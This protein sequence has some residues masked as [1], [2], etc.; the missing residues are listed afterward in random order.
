MSK[1]HKISLSLAVL[2][3]L[4]ANVQAQQAGDN[5]W[6]LGAA[7]IS[8]KIRLG[9]LNSE[10]PAAAPFNA[11]TA[12]ATASAGSADTLSLS[13]LHMFTDHVATE[14][15][16]G[17]P[18][19]ITLDVHLATSEHPSAASADVLT[20]AVVVKYLF[21]IPSDKVRPYVGLGVTHASFR[22][23]SANTSDPSVN[24]LGG[25]SAS[26]SSSWAPLYNLGFIYNFTDRLSLNA[27]VSYIPLKSTAT[28]VGPSGTTTTG[29]LDVNPTD[30]VI[31]L[32]FKF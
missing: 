28:F 5:I 8:P 18:P 15:S 25:T 1:H 23:V 19:K 20:P 16:I 30:Y 22:N 31:R 24:A 11:L 6:G 2:L 3:G 7:K 4:G 10:G 27:S 9:T 17:V 32:G 14:I 26:L 21:N 29:T 12:G 13:Y